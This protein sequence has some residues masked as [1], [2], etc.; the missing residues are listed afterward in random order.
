[1]LVFPLSE[2]PQLARGKGNK[3]IGIP[4]KRLASREEFV[5]AL[6]VVPQGASLTAHAGK[7]YIVL[8]PSD[9]DGYQGERGR[10]GGKLP[11][12]FQR[13]D[14]VEVNS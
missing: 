7:R 5:V 11:R 14:R 13:V 9:L 6:A 1:M 4:A 8:K 12:G 3:I 2:L 10:R